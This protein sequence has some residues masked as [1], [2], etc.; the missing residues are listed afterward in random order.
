MIRDFASE[1]RTPF[2]ISEREAANLRPRESVEDALSAGVI[3]ALKQRLDS[4]AAADLERLENIGAPVVFP[5]T[6]IAAQILEHSDKPDDLLRVAL[7]LRQ[8][9]KHFRASLRQVEEE[10][11]L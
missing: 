8:E 2:H 5:R 4:G 7:D 10:A 9:A 3:A 6:P 1:S 11:L